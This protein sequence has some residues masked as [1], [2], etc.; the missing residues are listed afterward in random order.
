MTY[1]S[2]T[3]NIPFEDAVSNITRNL[4]QHGFGVITSIDLQ[5]AFRQKLNLGFR[6]YCIL[7][8]C[9]PQFAYKAISLESHAGIML[10]CHVIVQERENGSVE[11]SAVNPLDNIDANLNTVQLEGLATEVGE[12][13]RAAVD[14]LQIEAL[15][16][17]PRVLPVKG[18]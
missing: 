7:G 14:E 11:V 18:L 9:N 15:P 1:Y 12:Q 5:D 10:S 17:A 13:L 3:L 6:K 16:G 8:A 2:R 4:K